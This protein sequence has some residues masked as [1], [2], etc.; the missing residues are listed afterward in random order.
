MAKHKS[1]KVPYSKFSQ[2]ILK[3]LLDEGFITDA[4]KSDEGFGSINITLK[5]FES[6]EPFINTAKR[7]SKPGRRMYTSADGIPKVHAGL[8]ISI[9]STSQGVLSDSEARKR[10]IGGEVL[11]LIA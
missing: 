5:Y 7:F 6:G 8:G 11:A 1:V 9:V 2:S 4:E 3:V 10:K